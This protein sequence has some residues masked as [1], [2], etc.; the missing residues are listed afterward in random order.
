MRLLRLYDENGPLGES[1]QLP[2]VGEWTRVEL[3]Q[4]F[5]A[6]AGQYILSLS[7]AGVEV[8]R[9]ETYD[10]DDIGDLM[11]IKIELGEPDVQ[12][13]GFIRRLVVLEKS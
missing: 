13:P 5:D 8:I 4:E 10:A 3:T 9:A 12:V 7:L 2:Q 11:D 6:K 1:M